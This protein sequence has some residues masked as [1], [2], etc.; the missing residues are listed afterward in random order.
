MDQIERVASEWP[1]LCLEIKAIAVT[2]IWRPP[3]EI[4]PSPAKALVFEMAIGIVK[5]Q[6]YTGCPPTMSTPTIC[7]RLD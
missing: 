5:M 1:I 7:K 2:V 3:C 4:R 6:T